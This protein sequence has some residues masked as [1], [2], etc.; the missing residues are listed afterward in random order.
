MQNNAVS[1][2]RR[3]GRATA[4][5]PHPGRGH[6]WRPGPGPAVGGTP[7]GVGVPADR[8]VRGDGGNLINFVEGD[9]LVPDPAALCG[10]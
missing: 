7:A 4:G 8:V 2:L 9:L 3:T 5:R 6:P 1:P 10:S